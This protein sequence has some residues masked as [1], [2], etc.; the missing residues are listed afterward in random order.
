L[1]IN[2]FRQV[3][4]HL[5]TC[6]IGGLRIRCSPNNRLAS[7]LDWRSLRRSGRTESSKS[8]SPPETDWVLWLFH[9]YDV[10]YKP[11]PEA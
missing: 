3:L 4:N 8:T 9:Q 1:E 5:A 6:V 11:Y 2:M 10:P 7:L